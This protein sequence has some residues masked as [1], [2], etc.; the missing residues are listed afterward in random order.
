[1]KARHS[2]RNEMSMLR[3]QDLGGRLHHVVC[4]TLVL[5]MAGS[6]FAA[7][8]T[9]GAAQVE[10][11]VPPVIEESSEARGPAVT[12]IDLSGSWKFKCDW[13]ETGL[14]DGWQQPEFDDS[15]WQD[16]NVPGAWEKQGITSGHTRWP[17]NMPEDGYNGYAW[18]RR[19]ITVPADWG[20]DAA[21]LRIG[22]VDDMDW[23]FVNGTL[24]GSTTEAGSWE[25][26]R[27]YLV[28]ADLLKPSEDAVIAIR[29]CD[30]GGEGGIRQ[31]PIELVNVLAEEA[32]AT[33]ARAALDERYTER[34][35]ELVKI[36]GGIEVPATM[37]VEGD[38]VAIGG[39]ADIR[40]YVKGE[41][42]A[43]GGS[44]HARD[45]SRIDGDAV[46]IGGRVIQEGDAHIGGSIVQ[47]P[48]LPGDLIS[49]I[50]RGATAERG[51]H[52][53]WG[54][55]LGGLHFLGR[56]GSFFGSLFFWA[57]V[58]GIVVL[59]FPRRLE[60]M[61]QALPAAPGRAAAYGIGGVFVTSA[62]AATLLLVG[63][64]LCVILAMIVIGIPL[65]PI[66]AAGILVALL[67][68]PLL[69][70]LGT[71]AVW[72]SLGRAA[73]ART[74]ATE[75]KAIWAALLGL[76][77]ISL[78]ALIPGIGGLI[79]LTLLIF[80][81]GVAV[82]TGMGAEAE[83]APRKL[84]FGRKSEGRATQEAPGETRDAD[85]TR[86]AD[87]DSADSG[88]REPTPEVPSEE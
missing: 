26:S 77:L 15:D 62:G 1:M 81:F 86:G 82:M 69:A 10:M 49:R 6:A 72:L 76:A 59:L 4:L 67:L 50:V 54:W 23:T 34:A 29:V 73:A 85:E 12:R 18:Y 25:R 24:V 5:L 75:P 63:I 17:G 11:A 47:G 3:W 65:I 42:V 78:A 14:A 44:I 20:R 46:A 79:K 84:G 64:A 66:V 56:A 30:T 51:F 2:G 52:P 32:A 41:V 55:P 70:L 27:A 31:G 68:L 83:W 16:L 40:G 71:V 80:G 33:E 19:H 21:R 35:A 57:I 36:G 13:L 45:G 8:P 61:A 58:T 28:P 74:G 88:R 9:E 43:V 60:V 48:G 53:F 7:A 39:S 38:A 37:V 87:L 22:G